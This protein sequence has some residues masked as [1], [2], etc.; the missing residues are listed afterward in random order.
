MVTEW[1]VQVLPDSFLE[2]LEHAAQS[3]KAAIDSGA[4]RCL[5]RCYV[6]GSSMSTQAMF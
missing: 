1:V 5:V 3:T 2:A 6:C 4:N